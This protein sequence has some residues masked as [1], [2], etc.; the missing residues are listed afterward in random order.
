[1]EETKEGGI[2][3][4]TSVLST[5]LTGL[6]GSRVVELLSDEFEFADLSLENGV[7]I[8]NFDQVMENFNNS[9]AEVVLHMAAKTDVDACEDDKIYGEEG[10]AWVVN[11][12]GTQNIVEAAKKCGKR[13]IYISTDFVFDGSK[14][15][16]SE[17][18]SPNPINWYGYTKYEGER[19]VG[20]SSINYCIVRLAYPYRSFFP[21]KLDFVRRI[22]EKIKKG[23][24][25]YA[26]TDHIFT[27]TFIDDIARVLR[28]LLKKD[29]RDVFHAVGT[30]SLTPYKAIE[31]I[32]DVFKLK[33]QIEKIT[34]EEYFR[35]RAFRPFKLA[36]KNDKITKL[37]LQTK[38]FDEG[39]G[40]MK[41][42]LKQ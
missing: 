15:Y 9:N 26:L 28:I 30:S 10:G 31:I 37:G 25:V 7:D 6:V 19:I 20:N 14:E 5:G 35:N 21:Q 1:M 41:K 11:V 33:G 39:L 42:Q 36:L 32:M 38:T 13:V 17:G 4:K 29:T 22:M 2:S 27:P 16:Y 8:T 34:R 23:E 40:E 3:M 18:D 12:I 24:K